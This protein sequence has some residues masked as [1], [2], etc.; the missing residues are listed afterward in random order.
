MLQSVAATI[1]DTIK[2]K[3]SEKFE[4]MDLSEAQEV[5]KTVLS[6]GISDAV[7]SAD[8]AGAY[9]GLVTL[10]SNV[11]SRARDEFRKP[12][13]VNV[14]LDVTYQYNI[15][16]PTIPL[17]SASGAT[18]SVSGNAK[19]RAVGGFTNGAELSWVGEDGP[20]AIIPLSMKR[21]ER[22]LELYQQVGDILGV[23]S[24]ANGGVYGPNVAFGLG[25]ND[26]STESLWGVSTAS[27][28]EENGQT[29]TTGGAPVKV[30]V[31]MQPEFIIDG[32]D[33]RSEEDIVAI[34]R[35]HLGEMADEIGGEIAE[36]LIK[37]FENMPVKG[38]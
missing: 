12:I 13:S 17:P 28:R 25:G 37:V 11:A 10:Q 29:L 2:A 15:K 5:L 26:L 35:R 38:V 23:A 4:A 20:E 19:H 30:E 16:N 18:V 31:T 22:G 24:N 21:R 27:Q 6:T 7:K 32:G 14:P 3:L 1:P 8:L 36:Q 33:S 9:A 34:I